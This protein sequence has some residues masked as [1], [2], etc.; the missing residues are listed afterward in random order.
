MEVALPLLQSENFVRRVP[1]QMRHRGTEPSVVLASQIWP[2]QLCCFPIAVCARRLGM[3]IDTSTGPV[4]ICFQ[5]AEALQR[6]SG[7]G[8]V[9]RR[10]VQSC[11]LPSSL[12]AYAPG[13]LQADW[14][15]VQMPCSGAV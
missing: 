14:K 8:V 5:H 12:Q 6:E 4:M 13:L 1:L 7:C 10:H 11:Q 9:Q 3:V 2:D 15:L